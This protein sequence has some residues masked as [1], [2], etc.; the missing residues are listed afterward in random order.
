MRLKD[1]LAV[2]GAKDAQGNPLP[3]EEALSQK[4]IKMALDGDHKMIQLILYYLEGKPP[5][6][7][8]ITSKGERLEGTVYLGEDADLRIDRI[9]GFRK[10]L[11]DKVGQ[12]DKDHANNQ[13]PAT[14]SNGS[15]NRGRTELPENGAGGGTQEG[16]A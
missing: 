13:R 14:E 15:D 11:A 12:I 2:L 7:I 9:F 8:D 16:A 3:L 1:G 10:L 6:S 5:Q 4:M